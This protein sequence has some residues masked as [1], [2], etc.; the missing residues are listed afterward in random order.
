MSDATVIDSL[1]R[2]R[3]WCEA[4]GDARLVFDCMNPPADDAALAEAE[5]RCGVPFPEDLKALYRFANGQDENAD[6]NEDGREVGLIPS[7]EHGDLAHLLMPLDEVT[8]YEDPDMGVLPGWI[9]FATNYGGDV[10]ACDMSDDSPRR[11]RVIHYVH[12]G[13]DVVRRAD[14]VAD[15]LAKLADDLDA[16]KV[17]F[18]EE[19]GLTFTQENAI[20][21]EAAHEAGELENYLKE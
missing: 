14:S 21:L 12:E 16:G 17:V 6:A 11:G 5:E 4:N 8:A 20:D 2:L 7:S 13:C 15:L 19:S 10:I 3:A 1:A 18:D 9:H